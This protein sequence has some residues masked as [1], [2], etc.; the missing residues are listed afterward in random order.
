[1]IP[2]GA[3]DFNGLAPNVIEAFDRYLKFLSAS[4]LE[5]DSRP[6]RAIQRGLHLPEQIAIAVTFSRVFGERTPDNAELD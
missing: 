4:L 6:S 2:T 5:L 1:M 3:R